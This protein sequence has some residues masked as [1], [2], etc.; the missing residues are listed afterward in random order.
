MNHPRANH[1]RH[2]ARR[3]LGFGLVELLVALAV[4]GLLTTG[5]LEIFISTRQ[6]YRLVD[7][8]SRVL[9]SGRFATA[10]LQRDLRMAGYPL[11]DDN[12]NTIQDAT[13]LPIYNIGALTADD[14]NGGGGGNNS[15]AITVMYQTDPAG[16]TAAPEPAIDCLGNSTDYSGG[17]GGDYTNG[18]TRYYAKHQYRVI[19]SGNLI[20]IPYNV[21]DIPQLSGNCSIGDFENDHLTEDCED[22]I[23]VEGIDNM[24][25]LYGVDTDV[26]ADGVANIFRNASQMGA[27]DWYDVVTVRIE[28][29]VNSGDTEGLEDDDTTTTYS[30]LDAPPLGPFNDRLMR[31]TFTTTITLRNRAQ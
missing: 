20:C 1:S 26:N 3:A 17:G 7:A 12:L 6:S 23:L 2:Q 15:D 30:L 4:T 29:L 27:N 18:N 16:V 13:T 25:I 14:V 5:I 19:P 9:E 10:F 24:Q 21:N 28:L 8:Q 31:R 11:D 22:H